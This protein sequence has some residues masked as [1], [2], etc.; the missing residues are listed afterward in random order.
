MP[1]LTVCPESDLL[2]QIDP[3]VTLSRQKREP[4]TALTLAILVGLGAAGAGTGIYSLIQTKDSVNALTRTVIRDID[5]L[6]RGLDYLEQTV[7]SLAEVVQQNRRGL[8]LSFLR[9]GGVCAALK[10]E[11]C[12]FKDK[13]GLVRDSIRRVEQSLEE[14]KKFG[15]K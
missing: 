14:T 10:E 15:S 3:T 2:P 7:G 5:E 9:E 11:C 1:K 8:D 13:S 4:V 12:F 6:K